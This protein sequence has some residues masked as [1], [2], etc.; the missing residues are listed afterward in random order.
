VL[1]VKRHRREVGISADGAGLEE[2][3][4]AMLASAFDQVQA[5]G[6]VGKEIAPGVVASGTDPTNL[7]GQ[8][9]HHGGPDVLIQPL[10]IRFAGQVEILA[11]DADNISV[12]ALFEL[13]QHGGPDE[14][15]AAGH[16]NTICA[17]KSHDYISSEHECGG[18][19]TK[20]RRARRATKK[21]SLPS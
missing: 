13:A 6:H 8:M 9:Y 7:G 3:F 4:H 17:G 20:R 19:N 16:C 12:P 15:A 14:P 21:R 1:F 18:I 11:A 5:H 10:D 2:L